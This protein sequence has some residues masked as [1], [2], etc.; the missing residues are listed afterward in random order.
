MERMQ[1]GKIDQDWWGS[2]TTGYIRLIGK[3][4][5]I[6]KYP[7]WRENSQSVLVCL[8]D[9]KEISVAGEVCSGRELCEVRSKNVWKADHSGL[10]RRPMHDEQGVI[11]GLEQANG[12]IWL[13]V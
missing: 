2:H 4:D 3:V 13:K 11:S 9:R 7:T 8:Q 5:Y 10:H 6:N 12:M 1:L